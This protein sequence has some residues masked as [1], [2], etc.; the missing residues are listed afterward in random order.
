M[1]MVIAVM[2]ALAT[3]LGEY[4]QTVA[5]NITNAFITVGEKATDKENIDKYEDMWQD[6]ID[7]LTAGHKYTQVHNDI[8]PVGAVYLVGITDTSLTAQEG[9]TTKYGKGDA[10]PVPQKGDVYVYREYIYKYGYENDGTKWVPATCGTSWGIAVLDK[11]RTDYEEPITELNH[12]K[13]TCYANLFKGNTSL[14]SGIG[15]EDHVTHMTSTYEGCSLLIEV[16]NIPTSATEFERT[17]AGCASL[18]KAPKLHEGITS[19]KHMFDGCTDMSIPPQ[20]PS[21]LVNMDYAFNNCSVL[22]YVPELP[23][24]LESMNYTFAGCASI[25]SANTIP[26]SVKNAKGAFENCIK[27]RGTIAIN[28]NLVSYDRMF[29]NCAKTAETEIKIAGNA[30]DAIKKAVG[31]TGYSNGAHVQ[32]ISSVG[33]LTPVN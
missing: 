14:L 5:L 17:F 28:A 13:I 7:D 2:I 23:E 31:K 24:T 4:M 33:V 9:A 32:Y 21:T 19:I 30:S 27:L 29:G 3:P 25:T 22:M 6:K 10:F 26:A 15:I 11:T 8:I 18:P 20:L 12:E 16:P 1:T